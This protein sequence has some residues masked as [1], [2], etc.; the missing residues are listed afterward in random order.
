MT[1]AIYANS[2]WDGTD[3]QGKRDQFV[4]GLEEN[5]QKQIYD[6]YN[7]GRVKREK[8]IMQLDPFMQAMERGLAKQGVPTLE[9]LN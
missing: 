7:P 3:N 9:E 1:A 2:N 6:L 8:K 4:Q 5:F